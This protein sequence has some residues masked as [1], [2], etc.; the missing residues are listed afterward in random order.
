TEAVQQQTEADFG[1]NSDIIS[2]DLGDIQFAYCTEFFVINLK[3]STT[4]ADIDKLRENL[5]NISDSVIC[6]GDLEMIKVHVHTNS[7]GVALTYALEL[8]E[9]D[10]P[11][12]KSVV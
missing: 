11:D 3:K 4:L 6:I 9:L 10:R 12:R 2:M 7:P 8:G 1:D 5:M